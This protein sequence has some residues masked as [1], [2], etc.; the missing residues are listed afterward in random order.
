M[1]SFKSLA[2][3]IIF[4]FLISIFFIV[5]PSIMI[6][7]S[8]FLPTWEDRGNFGAMFGLSGAIISGIGL[9]TIAWTMRLQNEQLHLQ[10]RQMEETQK[11]LQKQKGDLDEQKKISNQ[12]RFEVTFFNLLNISRSIE[13]DIR[14][15][16]NIFAALNKEIKD[17]IQQHT[18]SQDNLSTFFINNSN[19]PLILNYFNSLKVI[20]LLVHKSNLDNKSF[21]T[22]IIDNYLTEEIKILLFY[23][24]ISTLDN[25]F[26]ILLDVY[27]AFRFLPKK[28]L[29]REND[30]QNYK[31][32]R[33]LR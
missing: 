3:F 17:F 11:E 1:F 13:N 30:I 12:Q 29:Y 8:S 18:Y 10:K 26:F 24:G 23:Y 4:V 31:F 2:L 33:F 27:Q 28:K 9:F 32:T 5:A 6:V 19:Y 16:S 20:F 25:D 15:S 21:Y 14:L 7:N 22:E